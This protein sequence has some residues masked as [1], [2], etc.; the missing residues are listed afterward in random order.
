M[1]IARLIVIGSLLMGASAAAEAGWL[2]SGSG[3]P[4][5]IDNLQI[6]RL[7]DAGRRAHPLREYKYNRAGW[8]AQWKQIFRN[9]SYRAQPYIRGY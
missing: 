8:G 3:L 6:H 2:G 5:P 9:Y 4:K 1:S 7:A